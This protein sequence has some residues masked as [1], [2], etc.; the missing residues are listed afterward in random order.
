MADRFCSAYARVNE[1]CVSQLIPFNILVTT[2]KWNKRHFF[3]AI[4]L[5]KVTLISHNRFK[6]NRRQFHPI[7]Q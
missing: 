6:L 7:K 2:G 5:T 1:K 4:S 3:V